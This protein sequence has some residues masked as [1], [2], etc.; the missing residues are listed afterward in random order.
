MYLCIETILIGVSAK[1]E[2]PLKSS[3]AFG[4]ALNS[5]KGFFTF[6]PGLRTSFKSINLKIGLNYSHTKINRND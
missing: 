5:T 1:A 2:P 4:V 3:Q 6:Q